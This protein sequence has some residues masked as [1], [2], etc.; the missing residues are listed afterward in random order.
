MNYHAHT[1]EGPDGRP[2]PD[3]SRWQ[4]LSDHLRA[5][6][7][8]ARKFAEPLGLAE[9]AELAGW[10]HDLGK[11]AKRFQARLQDYSIHGTNHWS[12][13]HHLND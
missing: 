1:A 8:L 9:E 7:E 2:D 3:Q 10:L 13:L 11:Y 5:V 4:K 12:N 6:A